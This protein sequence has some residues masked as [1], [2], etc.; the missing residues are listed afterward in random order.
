MMS[1]SLSFSPDSSGFA[2]LL[3]LA[4]VLGRYVWLFDP[5]GPHPCARRTCLPVPL[6][7]VGGI[8]IQFQSGAHL[9]G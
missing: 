7:G 8:P 5:T 1:L 3:V 6:W 2:L 4:H 9:D